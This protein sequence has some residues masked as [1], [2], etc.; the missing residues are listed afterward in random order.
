V[1]RDVARDRTAYSAPGIAGETRDCSV[2]AHAVAACIDYSEAHALYARHG[3]PARC[4][5]SINTT[6]DCMGAIGAPEVP[7]ARC[8][9]GAFVKAHPAGHYVV[10]VKG[11]ALAIVDG[12]VHDWGKYTSGARRRVWRAW[13]LDV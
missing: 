8:T 3:R 11:H 1:V 2:R 13:R 7:L 12:V 5:T 9:V 4:G 10:H 6:F